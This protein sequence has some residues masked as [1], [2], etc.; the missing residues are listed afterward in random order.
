M[1]IFKAYD[2]RGE[3]PQEINEEIAYKIGRAIVHLLKCKTV[4]VGH[5]MRIG[6]ES[7]KH[8]LVDG[9]TD[10]GADVVDIGL[11]STDTLYFAVAEYDYPAGAVV[12][13]SHNPKQYN[14]IKVV[15]EKAIPICEG[16]GMEELA[17]IVEKGK[18]K[19]LAI[20][21]KITKK[22]F[23]L[24]FANA[25]RTFVELDKIKPLKVVMDAG[26][27][28]AGKT[29]PPIFDE[30]GLEITKLHFELDGKF[31]NH[32]PNPIIEENRH[33]CQKRVKQMQADLGVMWD[34]DTDR[35]MF[36]D[37]HGSF[38]RADWIAA[39]VSKHVL[40]KNK[41]ATIVYDPRCSRF[42]TD[43]IAKYGGR[44]Q[45]CRAGNPYFKMMM[46]K[47]DGPYSAEASGHNFYK[48]K[49][50]YYVDN[51]YIIVLQL[52]EILSKTGK[53][54]SQL[55]ALEGAGKYHASGEINFKVKDPKQKMKEV[56]QR[57]NS[58]QIS[59]LDGITVTYK[60]WW[61]NLR[62]SNTEPVVRLNLEAISQEIMEEKKRELTKLLT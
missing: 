62:A 42:L 5:D 23:L 14:G 15:K 21:G 54:L 24:E 1:S 27:G 59:H 40:L 13:A 60:S 3:Y 38:V 53:S 46:R 56:E 45:E 29:A 33:D 61:F 12:T 49:K 36:L 47:V 44:P 2:I 57:Y 41:G 30:L 25:C 51:G 4:V 11:C 58:A 50:G 18:A 22:D 9:I 37:E 31:P 10:E 17:Q 26:N 28:M 34:G 55:L 16:Y 7:L 32:D 52:L 35:C 19:G 48:F 8:S 6:S 39:I 43:T 20:K